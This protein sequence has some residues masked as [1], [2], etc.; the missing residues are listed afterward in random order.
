M[1]KNKI[2]SILGAGLLMLGMSSCHK[3]ADV[4]LS[5]A[6]QDDL[7]F[8]EAE[9]S[10][11]GKYR[12]FWKAMNT[13]YTLWDYEKECGLDWDAHYQKFH[14]R[15]QELDSLK[16]VTDSILQDLMNEM[17]APL[18]DGHLRVDF[19]NHQTGEYVITLP[20]ILRNEDRPELKEL[21]GFVPD[22]TTYYK[23]G[24]VVK[25]KEANTTLRAQFRHIY[26]TPGIGY[27]YAQDKIAELKQKATLTDGERLE[28]NGLTSFTNEMETLFKDRISKAM[29]EKYN[30]LTIK[31][32][33]LNIPQLY[34]INPAFDRTGINLKY[35]LTS[36]NVAYL[37]L[38]GFQLSAYMRKDYFAEMFPSSDERTLAKVE[39]IKAV[40]LEWFDTIQQLHKSGTLKG[41]IID[42]RSNGGGITYDSNY[43]LGAL[44]PEGGYQYGWSR[45]KRGVG[46]YDYSPMMPMLISTMKEEHEIVDDVPVVVLANAGSVSMSEMTSCAAK[47][48]PNGRVIGRRTHGGLCALTDN[49]SFAYNYSG[50][51]GVENITPV[52]CYVPTVAIF[53]MEKQS[54]EG[55]GVTP[56][57]EIALDVDAFTNE[58]RDTQYDR[59]LQYIRTG[60]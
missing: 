41:V 44:L 39:E 7:S 5:Y 30:A 59:A 11:A 13:N 28:L 29:V 6:F 26:Y 51:I 21:S 43:L 37:Y 33:Y 55:I 1:M 15:F 38:S 24:E 50:H 48:M 22:L 27:K 57:I 31:Y 36:D 35:A 14:P 47:V 58:G 20:S 32:D 56:D 53:N 19:K 23:K 17:V 3:D 9:K 10:F 42:V 8:A 16:N 18:H 2:Y 52:Y 4:V 46:R 49:S 25:M 40:W 54:L 34:S 60:E 12:V 45:F